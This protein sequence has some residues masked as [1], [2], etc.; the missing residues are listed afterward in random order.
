MLR[1]SQRILHEQTD[2][3][4]RTVQRCYESNGVPNTNAQTL[5][6]IQKTLEKGHSKGYIE[7]TNSEAPGIRFHERLR[8]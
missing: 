2:V 1:W 4:K 6:V 8:D 3:P 5:E 7:F